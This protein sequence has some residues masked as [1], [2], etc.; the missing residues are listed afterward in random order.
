MTGFGE[1]FKNEKRKSTISFFSNIFGSLFS[2]KAWFFIAV[3]IFLVATVVSFYKTIIFENKFPVECG[4]VIKME[5]IEDEHNNQTGYHIFIKTNS[6]IEDLEVKEN[7]YK[8]YDA[9]FKADK[10]T[11][12]CESYTDNMF[13]FFCFVTGIFALLTIIFLVCYSNEY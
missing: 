13:I 12:F 2:A 3:W 6:K 10:T 4:N 11:S 5:E 9:L 8:K 7:I 1:Y